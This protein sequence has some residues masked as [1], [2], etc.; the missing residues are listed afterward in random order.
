MPDIYVPEGP[1]VFEFCH[2]R[3]E[4]YETLNINIVRVAANVSGTVRT[5]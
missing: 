5:R 4:D 2:A 1:E 3:Q